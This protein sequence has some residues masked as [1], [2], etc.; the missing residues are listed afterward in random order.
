LDAATD[1]HDVFRLSLRAGEGVIVNMAGGEGNFDLRLLGGGA[2]STSDPGATVA[3]STGP[4]SNESFEHIAGTSG[5]YYLDVSAASGSGSYRV[6]TASDTDGDGR[7]DPADNCPSKGN[8]G[9]EDLD[10]DGVGNACDRYPNDPANDADGDRVGANRDNCPRTRNRSQTDWD[11]DGR[12][13]ACDRSARVRIERITDHGGRVTVIGSVRPRSL[14]P[15]FWRLR[16]SRLS[17]SHGRCRHV[18][19]TERAAKRRAGSGRVRLTVRLRP[20]SYRFRAVLH[21]RRYERARSR[22]VSR[23]VSS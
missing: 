5:T 19:V 20:G 11:G 6:E 10:H 14:D 22:S 12:G 16:V 13:D 9:Q 8:Y 7:S 3:G 21:N 18:F 15:I 1:Q 23:R 4:D 2:T 17:C